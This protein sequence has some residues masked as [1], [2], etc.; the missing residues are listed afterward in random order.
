MTESDEAAVI[1][2]M[3]SRFSDADTRRAAARLE[4]HLLGDRL[5]A[6][7]ESLRDFQRDM[8]AETC[9]LRTEIK[10]RSAHRIASDVEP[11]S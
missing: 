1:V 6:I 8:S 9:Q 7:A 3:G 4:G 10:E 5:A 11:S 2:R